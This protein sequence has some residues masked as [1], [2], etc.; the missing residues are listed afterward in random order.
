MTDII[1]IQEIWDELARI[2]ETLKSSLNL[3]G[4]YQGDYALQP[5]QG[6]PAMVNGIW[7]HPTPRMTSKPSA[8]PRRL[9][10]HYYFRFVY[11]RRIY[12][13]QNSAKLIVAELKALVNAYAAKYHLPDITNLPSHA[14]ILSANVGEI[15]FQ[16]EEDQATQQIA[17]DLKAIAFQM[18]VTVL[19]RRT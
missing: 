16:P 18:D 13:N 15:D 1:H 7:I 2:G 11:I 8:M 4:I 14:Q 5:T 12:Q 19:T 10:Q 3:K 6:I 17:A 9:E